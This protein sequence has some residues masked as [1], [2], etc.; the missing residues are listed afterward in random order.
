MP[1]PPLLA[2]DLRLQRRDV[3][4]QYRDGE[5]DGGRRGGELRGF[6]SK[7]RTQRCP[8]CVFDLLMGISRFVLACA[9]SAPSWPVSPRS[10]CR[11]GHVDWVWRRE[12]AWQSGSAGGQRRL[13][14][15][16]KEDEEKKRHRLGGISPSTQLAF[17][18][19]SFLSFRFLFFFSQTTS[20]QPRSRAVTA[21]ASSSIPAEEV[22]EEMEEKE[23]D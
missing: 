17:S 6:L 15:F 21:A 12:C 7:G 8:S 14:S 5:G 1:L 20:P 4:A 18:A 3:T 22:G 9:P 11:D 10:H 2:C 13:F 23:T 16:P 19:P